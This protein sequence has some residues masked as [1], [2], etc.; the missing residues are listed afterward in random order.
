MDLNNYLTGF[1]KTP[2]ELVQNKQGRFLDIPDISGLTILSSAS[3]KSVSDW[4]DNLDLEETRKRFRATIEI[5][6]VPPFWEDHLFFKRDIGIKFTI[7]R[8]LLIGMSPPCQVC[9]TYP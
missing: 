3:L 1:F 4:F 5:E 6:G 8:V 7:G 9:C 2:A